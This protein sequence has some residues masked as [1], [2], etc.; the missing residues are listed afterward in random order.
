MSRIGNKP[1]PILDGVSVNLAGRTVSV[2]GPKG[3]LSYDFRPE[4]DIN[5]DTDAKQVVITRKDLSVV[6][7]R[8]TAVTNDGLQGKDMFVPYSDI[9]DI[10]VK[11]TSILATGALVGIAVLLLYGATAGQSL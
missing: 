8:I 10:Q 6:K 7:F 1:I 3:T 5:V 9:S 11:K 4:V 2:E